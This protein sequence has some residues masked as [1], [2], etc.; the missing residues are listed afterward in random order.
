MNKSKALYQKACTLMPGGVNSP[1]RAFLSVES[2]PPFI[3]SGK[4]TKLLDED[5][6]TYTDYTG[7]WGP[8]IL[9]HAHPKVVEAVKNAADKG[10]SFGACHKN[11]ITL[12]AQIH[13]AMPHIEMLRLVSSGT[14]AAMSAMRLARAATGRDI[15]IKFEGCYHG[16]ADAFLVGAGSGALTFG[17]P[18]SPGVTQNAAQDTVIAEFNSL[19]SVQA[20]FEKYKDKIACI[21][22]E[23]VAGNM[24]VIPPKD[25]FLKGLRDLCDQSDSLLIFDEVITGFRLGYGGAAEKYKIKPDLTILGKIIG[26]GMPVGAYGGRK[27]LMEMISPIGGVY[28]AGTN[29]GNPI[30]CAAG[31]ATLDILKEENPY[32][33]LDHLAGKLEKGITENLSDFAQKGT[34][35]RIAS[36]STTFFGT[37][38]IQGLTDTKNC[39]TK[40]YARYHQAMFEKGI[41]L[42]PSQFE[43]MFIS[44]AHTENDIDQ[45]LEI[46]KSVL[47]K[48][49]EEQ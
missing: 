15:V 31:I 32:E 37:D 5:G 8:L 40:R 38:K 39:N 49:T 23:P 25:G 4:G 29:S 27:D 34:I 1:V 24:G 41:F 13:E 26:G 48:M 22:V 12:A 3:V 11:E 17:T 45:M 20:C 44:T 46:Q 21:I 2:S 7:A 42:P 43:A 6:K 10:L 14:E 35:N 33:K 19:S 36:M 47:K 16:H 30:T 28:Q 9:G 18:S